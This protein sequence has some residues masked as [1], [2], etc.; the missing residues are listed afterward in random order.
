MLKLKLIFLAHI[1]CV[2]D[3]DEYPFLR[4]G[5]DL[6]G[7]LEHSSPYIGNNHPK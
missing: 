1:E 3:G 5:H 6:V 4:H 2:G 7:G